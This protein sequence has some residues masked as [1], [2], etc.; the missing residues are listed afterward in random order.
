METVI[1]V[2]LNSL[3]A[4]ELSLSDKRQA[5]GNSHSSAGRAQKAIF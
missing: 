4:N 2:P 1:V 5:V 3:F